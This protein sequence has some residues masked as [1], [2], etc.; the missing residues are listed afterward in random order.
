MHALN[1]G[2]SSLPPHLRW[3]D[4]AR[5]IALLGFLW[6]IYSIVRSLGNS[7]TDIAVQNAQSL[8]H[9][10]ASRGLAFEASIQAAVRSEMVFIAANAYYLLHFPVTVG[11]LGWTF[12]RDRTRSFGPFR[13]ALVLATAIGLTLHLVFPLAPPR[14]L[15]GFLDTGA[16]FGPDPYALP[17]SDAANQFAA[18][19]SMHV[20][21]AVLVALTLAWSRRASLRRWVPWIHPTFTVLAV[22]ITANHYVSDAVVGATIAIVSW[23]IVNRRTKVVTRKSPPAV[24]IT[25]T[26]TPPPRATSNP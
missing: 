3:R 4:A 15:D 5:N 26:A 12:F 24:S 14:M 19:P 1:N 20:T 17:G 7:D 13:N 9:W 21:W 2:S 10:Q 11:L 22:V 18:M 8:L 6:V 23:T 16:I 25:D